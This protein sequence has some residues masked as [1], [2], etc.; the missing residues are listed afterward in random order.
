MITD[1]EILRIL[2]PNGLTPEVLE[3]LSMLIADER[4]IAGTRR[5]QSGMAMTGER[6]LDRNIHSLQYLYSTY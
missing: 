1:N 5:D 2:K 3:N 4:R 6:G